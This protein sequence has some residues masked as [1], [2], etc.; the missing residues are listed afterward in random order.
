MG[1][2]LSPQERD[3]FAAY[4]EREAESGKQ[5]LGQFKTLPPAIA[6]QMVSREQQYVSACIIIAAK[7]RSVEDMTID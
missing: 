1:L 6:E 7:L 2:L 4:L 5:M 3:R